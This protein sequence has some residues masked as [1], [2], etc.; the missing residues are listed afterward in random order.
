MSNV[1]VMRPVE[2][3]AGEPYASP[4]EKIY[5]ECDK[6]LSQDDAAALIELYAPDGVIESPL[7][8]HLLGKPEGVCRGRDE[9]R[10]FFEAVAVR[11]PPVRQL[12]PH[13]LFDRWQVSASG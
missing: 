4:V 1:H 3:Q 7:I 8:P 11:K 2:R 6:A 12:L 5:F 13:G 10:L 9:M